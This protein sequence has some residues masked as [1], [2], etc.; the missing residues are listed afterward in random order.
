MR[1]WKATVN[2]LE[3]IA[4]QHN[5]TLL[6]LDEMGEMSAFELGDAA[7]ML[8]NG[9]EKE[10]HA[11]MAGSEKLN[12]E[13]AFSLKR[14]NQPCLPHGTGWE[15]AKAG[16]EIRL[17]EIPANTG[18]Y[19]L[20]EELH[21]FSN[22]SIFADTISK[23]AQK[24]YGTPGREFLK[25][26]T[27]DVEEAK[28]FVKKVMDDFL[29]AAIPEGASGQIHRVAARFALIAAAGE[30]AVHYNITRVLGKDGMASIGWDKGASHQAALKCF[31]DWLEAFGGPGIQEQTQI[32][33]D[34]RYF[35]EQHGESRFTDWHANNP[36]I[37]PSGSRTHNRAGFRRHTDKGTEFYIFPESFKRDICKGRD[38]RFVKETLYDNGLLKKDTQGKFTCSAKPASEAKS[39]RFYV[40]ISTW[41]EGG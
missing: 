23:N 11:L 9:Q 38:E 6:C 27:Q 4:F 37:P 35:L 20:F 2:G 33:A 7:Y 5:D 32:L 16:Q 24:Y 13:I 10:E 25:R 19:G 18:K 3:T 17:A 39:R 28:A 21:G 14:R 1:K 30:L 36:D 15:K 41:E 40:L 26:L 29:L 34:V 22:G 8:A 31:Q 12:V